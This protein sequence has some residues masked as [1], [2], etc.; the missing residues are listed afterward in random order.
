MLKDND[1]RRI[2]SYLG[3]SMD[4]MEIV[5]F[6]KELSKNELL[7]N[8]LELFNTINHYL[9]DKVLPTNTIESK[10]NHRL[11]SFL[12]SEEA[13]QIRDKIRIAAKYPNKKTYSK[14]YRIAAILLLGL[15]IGSLFIWNFNS[16]Y[17]NQDIFLEYYRLDDIP[18]FVSRSNKNFYPQKISA[19]F[20]Q[21][22]YKEAISLF[23]TY[24]NGETE[25][26][27]SLYLVKG[28]AHLAIRQ[29]EDAVESFKIVSDSQLLN[30]EKGL[31][32][33]AI[34]LLKSNETEK[35]VEVLHKIASDQS[36]FKQKEAKE[37]LKKLKA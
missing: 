4:A 35:C 3:N 23:E 19:L 16:T 7:K 37:I 20:K 10:L 31:W 26:D 22:K 14:I 18:S 25:V 32:F 5:A 27:T 15:T 13:K 17:N 21:Q 9:G 24:K 11:Y 6:E 2:E 29:N 8:E 34:A 28:A 33:Y 30:S 36:H 1:Y 12:D